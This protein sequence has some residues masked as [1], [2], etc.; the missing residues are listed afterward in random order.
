MAEAA[1]LSVPPAPVLAFEDVRIAYRTKAGE[2]AAI[3]GVSLAIHRG[4]ALGLVG[5]SGS[6]KSTLAYAALG[7]FGAN[8]RLVGGRI[9]FEGR[10]L[11]TLRTAE[12]K[13]LRGARIAMVFQEPRASLNPVM[14]VGA[15]IEEVLRRHGGLSRDEARA[16]ALAALAEVELP[17]PPGMLRRFPHELSGGQLQRIVIAIALSAEPSLLILDE[18]TTGL[19]ATIEAAVLDLVRRLRQRR[20]TAVLLIS[21]DISVVSRV[22]E[23]IAVLYGG[24]LVEEAPMRALIEAPLHPYTRALLACRPRLGAG[25]RGAELPAIPGRPPAPGERPR[26]CAFAPRCAFAREN[27]CTA[28]PIRLDERGT[29]RVRCVRVAE[30]PPWPAAARAAPSV[31]GRRAERSVLAEIEGLT[32]LYPARVGLFRKAA[33]SVALDGVDLTVERGET[34]ALVGESGSGKSTLARI[35]V[36]LEQASGG[37]VR[38]EGEAVGRVAA[39][40]RPLALQR[41]LQ[42]VFQNPDGTLNP[43]HSV[44]FALARTLRKLGRQGRDRAQAVRE[45]L[46]AVRLPAAYARAR[47][48]RLSGGEKQRVAIARALAGTPALLIADEP[49]S[50]LDPSVQA[51][52]VNLLAEIKRERGATLVFISHDLALVE[53]LADRVAVLYRGRLM[54]AGRLDDVFAPPFHPY[55]ET[56]LDAAKAKGEAG[57][58]AFTPL[59]EAA[60]ADRGGCPFAPRCPRKLGPICEAEFPPTQTD[61]NGHRIACHIPRAELLRLQR[62]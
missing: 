31:E 58:A 21:H 44:G 4:E 2:V 59:R 23:R 49:V 45:L 12:L 61:A 52:I 27:L 30:L 28:A 53:H 5:E 1:V 35:L 29:H 25:L 8:G 13:A 62:G 41:R 14:T 46:E 42:M 19:D 9:L 18:P 50:A 60:A 38:I 7:D 34:L 37:E 32:K 20:G 3:A 10:E 55:T 16:R 56:L 40:R 6:G 24:E 51:A 17:D 54:E 11:A 48:R 43:R 39:E 15:Q 57:A 26:G 36:G 33:A 22:C 47:P